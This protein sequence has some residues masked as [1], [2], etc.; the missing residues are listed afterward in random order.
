MAKNYIVCTSINPP[1]EA[2]EKFDRMSGWKLIVV[3]DLKTP[4]K[5]SLKKGVYLSP[6]QQEKIDLKLSNL[7]GW[8]CIQR[9]NFGFIHAYKMGADIIA[10]VDDDNI[11][12]NFWGKNLQFNRKFKLTHANPKSAVFDPL[13]LTNYSHLWHRG[14]PLQQLADRQLKR[15]QLS[16]RMGSFE[17]QADFWNGDPDVDAVCRA[18]YSPKCLFTNDSFP[19]F[20]SKPSPF[21]SQN[22]FLSRSVF[23]NYFL[24]P[25]IGRMDDVWAAYY[26]QAMG[27]RVF[28]SHPSVT[29]KRNPH[30]LTQDFENEILGYKLSEKFILSAL[31]NPQQALKKYLPPKSLQAFK[32]YRKHFT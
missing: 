28:Y 8:N 15:N 30:S 2:I 11:P 19:F 25:H 21:N 17:I 12:Y 16:R 22:T 1:T 10:T 4:K 32:I 9:R 24:F 7:I 27:H 29:Q 23:P 26:V 13:S 18:A 3:G 6:R 14:F 31:E 20:S 5:Y